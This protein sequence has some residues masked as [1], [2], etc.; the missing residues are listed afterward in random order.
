LFAGPNDNGF[1]IL[2]TQQ[3]ESAST[4]GEP[5]SVAVIFPSAQR[6]PRYKCANLFGQWLGRRTYRL[7]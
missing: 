1:E 2:S 4:V 5:S 6:A 3:H 7:R